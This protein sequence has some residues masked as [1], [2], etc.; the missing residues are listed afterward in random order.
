MNDPLIPFARA[1]SSDGP[2]LIVAARQSAAIRETP[3]HHHIRGQLLGAEHGLL[4]IDAE[5]CRWVVP[6]THAVWI[7]PNVPHGLCS[8]GPY[9][10][11]N[12]YISATACDELP[13]K[14]AVL[15]ITN[16]L[17][18]AIIR[19]ASWE[20]AELNA[21]QKR[22]SGVILDEIGTLPKVNLGLPMPQDFRLL[23]VAQALSV[24]PNDGRRME[25]WADWAGVS[26]RTL[27]R[28]FSAETGFSFN[29]GVS[30]DIENYCT[31]R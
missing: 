5:N 7:P 4:T 10:G 23:R 13:D 20:N 24:N 8:H 17:R 21:P 11:W 29:E 25:E 2:T 27:T 6:A 30:L 3:R 9:A 12:V 26:S 22:L 15:S 1:L 28:R 14:P 16:L 18:E 31:L 19:A